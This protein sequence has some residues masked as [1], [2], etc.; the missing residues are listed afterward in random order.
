MKL[1]AEQIQERCENIIRTLHELLPAQVDYA[2]L[3]ASPVPSS[4]G[5]RCVWEDPE[6]YAMDNAA[7]LIKD[8]ADHIA[9]LEAEMAELREAEDIRQSCNN[10]IHSNKSSCPWEGTYH[11]RGQNGEQ[12]GVCNAWKYRGL[13]GREGTE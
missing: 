11:H 4:Y 10:C 1:T 12:I 9:Q 2:E 6:P 3:V 13:A 7:T 5:V 8:L